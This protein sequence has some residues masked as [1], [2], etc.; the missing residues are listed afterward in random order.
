MFAKLPNGTILNVEHIVMVS[1]PQTGNKGARLH[2]YV[3]GINTPIEVSGTQ[4][5]IEQLYVA[6]Q[7][8]IDQLTP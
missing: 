2:V 1:A 6:L 3:I 5:E 7:S 4:Q 8:K